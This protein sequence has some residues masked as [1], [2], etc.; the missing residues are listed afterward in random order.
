[1]ADLLFSQEM[2]VSASA[3]QVSHFSMMVN[4]VSLTITHAVLI[5]GHVQMLD[6]RELSFKLPI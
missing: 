4:P 5:S 1:M 2:G 6:W 3:T